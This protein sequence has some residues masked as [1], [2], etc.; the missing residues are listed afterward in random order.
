[1][2]INR[3]AF[4]RNS[5]KSNFDSSLYVSIWFSSFLF[6]VCIFQI[7]RRLDLHAY[8]FHRYILK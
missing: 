7:V 1:M 6:L 2:V 5:L 4:V 8:M 3:N